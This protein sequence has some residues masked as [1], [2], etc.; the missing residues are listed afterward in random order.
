MAIT[1][2]RIRAQVEQD[3]A[4]YDALPEALKELLLKEMDVVRNSYI[5][6]E[7]RAV[8]QYTASPAQAA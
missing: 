7:R 6:P 3:S 8:I 1:K 4:A 2:D 5:I